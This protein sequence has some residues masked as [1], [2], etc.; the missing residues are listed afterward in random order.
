MVDNIVS[1]FGKIFAR[2]WGPRIDDVLRVA[3]LTLLKHPNP[4]L[5]N[6]PP[7]LTKKQFRAPLVA[8]LED[9]EGLGGF[10]DWYD[11]SPP[12]LRAQVIGP[13]LARLRAFLLRDFVK[14][15]LGTVT[16]SFDM[17][18]VLDGGIL[19]ARLP[20]GQLGE[21]TA[22]LMGSFVLGSVWQAATAR[23][24]LPEDRRR[25]AA[26]YVDEAHNVLNLA[27]SVADMLAEARGYRLSLVL[28]HQDLAQLP[29]ETLQ[30]IS[31]NARNKIFFTCSPEDA[32]LLARHTQ[33]ELV[34]HDLANLDAFTAATRLTLGAAAT[35]A[36]TLATNRLPDRPGRLP[37]VRAAVAARA[38]SPRSRPTR[39]AAAASE[40]PPDP[41]PDP[42]SDP[43]LDQRAAPRL[44]QRAD[45]RADA[46]VEAAP[47]VRPVRP[48][49]RSSRPVTDAGSRT[50]TA[51]GATTGAT[52][53]ADP[54]RWAGADPSHGPGLTPGVPARPE[55]GQ[56]CRP[57]AD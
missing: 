47:E 19:I 33:P 49:R 55:G 45:P 17:G 2:H 18:A 39:P 1:I 20:K 37:L 4:T 42:P 26:C 30:A 24:R 12:A 9:P 10:W 54:V 25:D 23:S 56:Q 32:R 14:A 43:E 15:T 38:G 52:T 53:D 8:G 44:D 13:V 5:V 11:T 6:V 28:A 7:L 31:A 29:R 51:G 50:C 46:P 16:S 35:P 34:E 3:C 41:P 22:K 57:G 27:G 40:T 48:P 36:F 21:E